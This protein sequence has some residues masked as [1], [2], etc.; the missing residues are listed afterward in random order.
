MKQQTVDALSR[1]KTKGEHKVIVHDE[2]PVPTVSQAFFA[3][4]PQTE[5]TNIE[6][7]SGRKSMFFFFILDS[8]IRAGITNN[9][10]K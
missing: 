4:A 2:V 5:I 1:F 6:F 8:C 7:I 3:C 9:E 10:K